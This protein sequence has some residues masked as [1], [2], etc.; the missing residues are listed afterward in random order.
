MLL[1]SFVA[2]SGPLGLDH[3]LLHLLLDQLLLF[4]R[5]HRLLSFGLFARLFRLG[6]F[7]FR[8]A[9]AFRVLSL[10]FETLKKR[11]SKI[12]LKRNNLLRFKNLQSEL[13]Y[14]QLSDLVLQDSPLKHQLFH[15]GGSRIDVID[16]GVED[17]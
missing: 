15:R 14:P 9:G 7:T 11:F 10:G 8:L 1:Q 4:G 6:S 13:G 5:L 2:K 16:L 17:I 3:V 12:F